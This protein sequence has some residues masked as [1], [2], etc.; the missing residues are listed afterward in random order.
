MEASGCGQ[1]GVSVHRNRAVMES[2]ATN[3]EI[4]WT[5][6]TWLSCH[7]GDSLRE[8]GKY[9]GCHVPVVFVQKWDVFQL[10]AAGR[11]Y[12]FCVSFF[13]GDAPSLASVA[14]GLEDLPARAEAESRAGA[15]SS[16]VLRCRD[17]ERI[18]TEIH[19]SEQH[20]EWV[21]FCV[22]RVVIRC[23][24]GSQVRGH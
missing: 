17:A 24:I 16:S 21:F 6:E 4:C 22:Q 12:I 20:M 18:S 9:W 2:W 10:V 3:R 7:V 23:A 5:W 8:S 13:L 19:D 15:R 14:A 11:W 1:I